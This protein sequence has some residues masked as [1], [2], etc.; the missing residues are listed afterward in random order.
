MLASFDFF[1]EDV[2]IDH[3]VIVYAFVIR[4]I[5]DRV[6][7]LIIIIVKLIVFFYLLIIL[8]FERFDL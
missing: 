8:I 5:I 4:I 3:P 7:V 2:F 6:N 1:D